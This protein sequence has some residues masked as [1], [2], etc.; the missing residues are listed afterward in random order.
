VET[1]Q[2]YAEFR[3][4]LSTTTESWCL[5]TGWLPTLRPPHEDKQLYSEEPEQEK[6]HKYIVKNFTLEK[7]FQDKYKTKIYVLRN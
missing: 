3:Q 7:T 4:R 2:T 1:P 6:I 5:I